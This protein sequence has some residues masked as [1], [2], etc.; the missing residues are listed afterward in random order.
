MDLRLYSFAR[1]ITAG[2]ALVLA[3][4]ALPG[5]GS[6][7]GPHAT[8]SG[9]VTVNGEPLKDGKIMC[10]PMGTGSGQGKSAA[11]VEGRY[12][13]ADVPIGSDVFTFS[14]A[15]VTGK[16]IRGPGGQ[17]E[18]ER[19]NVIPRKVLHEGVERKIEANGTQDF[20]LEGPA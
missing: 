4:G 8:I 7:G 10:R 1:A 16:S 13:L 17:P 6:S 15:K 2:M 19:V 3:A 11:V 18:P 12:K 14:G 20:A 9:S 5:C